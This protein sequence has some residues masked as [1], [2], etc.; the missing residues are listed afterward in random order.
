MRNVAQQLEKIMYAFQFLSIC[1]ACPNCSA[2]TSHLAPFGVIQ[3]LHRLFQS[4]DHYMS[5]C[6]LKFL[7]IS[8]EIKMLLS[9]CDDKMER[10]NTKRS[11]IY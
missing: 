10:W 11:Q 3:I 1:S 7:Y 4:S 8:D 9:L 5:I 2:R 6:K